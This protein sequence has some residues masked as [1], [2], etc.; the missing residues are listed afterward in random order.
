MTQAIVE[1][2]QNL[3]F[4]SESDAKK[5]GFVTMS[6]I[7]NVVNKLYAQTSFTAGYNVTESIQ[8]ERIDSA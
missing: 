1:D 3:R 2:L 5:D 4:S 8:Y 7:V 6:E